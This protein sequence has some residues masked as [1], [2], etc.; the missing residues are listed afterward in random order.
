[1]SIA[2]GLGKEGRLWPEI[3]VTIIIGLISLG[4]YSHAY[5]NEKTNKETEDCRKQL[6]IQIQTN[7]TLTLKNQELEQQLQQLKTENERARP[8]LDI[9]DIAQELERQKTQAQQHIEQARTEAEALL[10]KAAGQ[11]I[12]AKEKSDLYQINIQRQSE[13]VLSQAKQEASTIIEQAR[14][15]ALN[16]AA[17]ALQAKDKAAEYEQIANA[18]RNRIEGYG[19]QYIIPIYSLIDDL[20]HETSYTEAGKELKEARALTRYMVKD[21][22][23]AG[24]DYIE[25]NRRETAISFVLDAFNGKVDSILAEVKRDNYGT[26]AQKIKDAYHIVNQNG[27]AFRNAHIKQHYLNVRLNELKWACI[28]HQIKQQEIEEQRQ[29]KARI[30]EEE[31]AMR[32]YAKAM[33]EAQKEEE[34]LKRLIEKAQNEVASANEQTRALHARQLADLESKLKEAEEKNQR[35][36][37]MAQQTKAG[38]VYIISNIGSFGEHIYKIGMTRRLE[39]L[40]RI[41]E[42]GDAS[43]PFEFDVHAMIYSEDAPKLEYEL[44][45]KFILNQVNKVNPRKEFFRLPLE[46]I[47][48]H[49]NQLGLGDVVWTMNAKAAQYRESLAIEQEITRDQNA[50][51]EWERS[52]IK[53]EQSI[54]TYENEDEEQ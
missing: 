27:Q 19:N 32:E 42:L 8:Y 54:H 13:Q 22:S 16:I 35:A 3:I 47:A 7:D 1:M 53:Q 51:I 52:Q 49:V 17:D 30:R 6:S 33:R 9:A 11:S 29:I 20:A 18:M 25:P 48:Q 50:R 15:N 45:R 24:C 31:R 12:A 39:P 37:S 14:Q 36:L 28:A 21:G 2:E 23:A 43:V 4:I 38:N 26:L 40:D 41:R 44:H 5:D 46:E 10:Q 34:T